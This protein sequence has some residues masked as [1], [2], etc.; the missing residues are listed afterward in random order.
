M[1]VSQKKEERQKT[2]FLY[3][4]LKGAA[5]IPADDLVLPIMRNRNHQTFQTHAAR[6]DNYKG[7]FFPQTIRDWNALPD[8]IIT[9]AEGVEDGVARF[10][11]LLRARD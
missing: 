6:T 11:S 3:K 10:T 1:G 7:S 4:S 2:D 5:S 8:L 9:S